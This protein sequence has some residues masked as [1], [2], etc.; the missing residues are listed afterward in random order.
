M[1][2]QPKLG[3]QAIVLVITFDLF[4]K[5]S[6][7]FYNESANISLNMNLMGGG[8]F[9]EKYISANWKYLIPTQRSKY[10]ITHALLFLIRLVLDNIRFFLYINGSKTHLE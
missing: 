6:G 2:T 4:W 10:P 8:G 9:R 1:L 3:G 5:L 7:T